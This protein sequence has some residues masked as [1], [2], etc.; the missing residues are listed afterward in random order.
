MI[1]LRSY[2]IDL[3]AKAADLVEKHRIAYLAMEVRTGKTL[4]ALRA[5]DLCRAKTVL[6][7]T[8]KRAIDSIL[9]DH[10]ALDPD[11]TITVIN[12][13]SLHLI[14]NIAFDFIIIDEAHTL[15]AFPKPSKATKSIRER[16]GHLRMLLLSGTPSVESGSQLYHQFW[17]QESS[18]VNKY[19]N[20]YKWAKIFVN[21]KQIRYGGVLTNDYSDAKR[22]LINKELGH[23]MLTYSQ[24][25][26]GFE[27]VISEKILNHVMDDN[28]SDLI[29]KMLKHRLIGENNTI[30]LG[31]TA[32]KLMSKV[33]Q[34]SGGSV[35]CENGDVCLIDFSK[36]RF[37]KSHFDGKKL[38]IFYFFKAEFDIL[39]A[40]FGNELTDDLAEFNTTGKHIALQQ[41]AGSEGISLKAADAIVYYSFG[42][43]GKNYIQGRDRLT[44]IDRKTNDVYFVFAKGDINE[45]IYKTIR[46]KK[47]Y[48]EKMFLKDFN[49]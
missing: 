12:R 4:T 35:I 30:V 13:E 15:G 1:H 11:F 6:F 20:F 41:V 2:Q 25:D 47:R 24:Q 27:A 19:V 39:K 16:W 40:V 43:S 5:A 49:I 38:A 29:S 44:T 7:I 48:N 18:P 3:S 10:A 36:A 8:K 37:I 33:H 28:T 23:L 21:I 22:D 17:L 9:K 31:D 32:A 46:E 45:R 34:L 26:A 42:Y 14:G